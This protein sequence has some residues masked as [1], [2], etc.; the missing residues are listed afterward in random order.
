MPK[1]HGIIVKVPKGSPAPPGFTLVKQL[2]RANV[3]KKN[4]P[5]PV[6]KEQIDDITAM[7][8]KIGISAEVKQVPDVE[9][10]VAAVNRA[11]AA[12]PNGVNDLEAALRKFGFGGGKKK[13]RKNRKSTR[14]TRRRR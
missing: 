10:A 3:Y 11:A 4:E 12:N 8:S 7:F 14:N 5:A 1:Q 9:M 2:R 6:P 13:T